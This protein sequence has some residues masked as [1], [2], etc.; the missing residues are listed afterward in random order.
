M[1]TVSSSFFNRLLRLELRIQSPTARTAIKNVT[2]SIESIQNAVS[3]AFLSMR[4]RQR[5]LLCHPHQLARPVTA[6]RARQR[7]APVPAIRRSHFNQVASE[8]YYVA[9]RDRA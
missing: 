6:V 1:R 9:F 3:T 8:F 7:T 5:N 4:R 2:N